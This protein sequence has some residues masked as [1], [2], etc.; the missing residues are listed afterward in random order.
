MSANHE[1]AETRFVLIAKDAIQNKYKRVIVMDGVRNFKAKKGYMV[2]ITL[3]K[4]DADRLESIFGFHGQKDCD[5]SS[6]FSG[7]SKIKTLW[8][9]YQEAQKLLQS[10]GRKL[11]LVLPV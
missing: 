7:I 10:L 9:Q 5:T 3:S 11:S 2:Y 4:L 6:S 8:K 1:E